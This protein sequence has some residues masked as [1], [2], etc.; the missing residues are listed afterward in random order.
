M[1]FKGLFQL[2]RFY[3][4]IIFRNINRQKKKKKRGGDGGRGIVLSENIT[5]REN[6]V[7]SFCN[8]RKENAQSR[9]SQT[10][11]AG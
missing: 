1:T 9:I 8:R 4:A 6:R 11:K 2:K 10:G 7:F 3:D 5:S